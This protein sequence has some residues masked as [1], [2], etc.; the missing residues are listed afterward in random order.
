MATIPTWHPSVVLTP[1]EERLRFHRFGTSLYRLRGTVRYPT[2][3]V[4]QLGRPPVSG[5]R[6][7]RTHGLK[8]GPALL[9]GSTTHEMRN[10]RYAA[11]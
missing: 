8:G 10:Q 3:R 2:P 1:T 7:I 4:F 5:V 11:C 6:E 9:L